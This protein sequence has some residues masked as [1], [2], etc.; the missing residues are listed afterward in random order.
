MRSRL[1]E[2][3]YTGENRCRPCTPLNVAV[4]A[5]SGAAPAVVRGTLSA[6]P[7]VVAGLVAVGLRGYSLPGTP[8]VGSRRPGPVRSRFGGHDP[9]PA[10]DLPSTDAL[11][12]RNDLPAGATETGG[13]G[14]RRASGA[15]GATDHAGAGSGR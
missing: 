9:D 12:D 13:D 1:R 14:R 6:L 3:R 11:V 15:T 4:V 5:L 7:V 2:P 8:R 10:A